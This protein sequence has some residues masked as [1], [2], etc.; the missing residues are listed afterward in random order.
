[1]KINDEFEIIPCK[2]YGWTLIYTY[3]SD[4]RW[5]K[6]GTGKEEFYYPNI[7]LCLKKAIDLAPMECESIQAIFDKWTDLMD[8]IDA[9]DFLNMEQP[10]G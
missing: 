5:S 10:N 9:M 3:I 7:G 1:M 2:T 8:K 4:H 6:T